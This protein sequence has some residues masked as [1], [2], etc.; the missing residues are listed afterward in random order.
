MSEDQNVTETQAAE[1]RNRRKERIGYVVSDKMQK[2]I[3][4]E[5]E[6]R[7]SHPLYG[8]IIRTT[9]KVK[10]HDENGDAGVG[11]RVRIMETR[12]LSATKHWRLVEVLEKAK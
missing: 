10:A 12:P 8:K 9:S 6:D 2:T 7:K 3:V 11:D 5:L 4:V 1:V